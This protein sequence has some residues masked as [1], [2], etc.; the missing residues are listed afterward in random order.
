MSDPSSG[1]IASAGLLGVTAASF[2]P[3]VDANAIIGAFAGALF[4]MVFAKDLTALA[5]IG[6]FVAS[7]IVGYYVSVEAI[8]QQ[9][10][11]TSGLPAF[12]GALFAVVVCVSLLEWAQGGKTPGWLSAVAD[13]IRPGGRK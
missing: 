13:W 11:I 5:R 6:Y 1:V 7:W 2:L 9:W 10:S 4:F 12:F 3:G 8:G